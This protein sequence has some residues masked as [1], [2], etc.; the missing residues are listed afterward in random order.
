M[1]LDMISIGKAFSARVM[2]HALQAFDRA[3]MVV[4]AVC[5]GGAILVMVF[6]LYTL[7]LSMAAKHDAIEAAA[8]EPSVPQVVTTFPETTELQPLLERLQ[9]R[10]PDITFVLGGDKTLT[11][12]A[13]D[14]SKFRLWL[15]VLGYI[16]TVIPQYRWTMKEFCVGMQCGNAAPMKAVLTAEKITFTLPDAEKQ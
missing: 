5:W 16:D 3:M 10:F 11:V 1:K 2:T 7:N 12:T 9:K 15:T 13:V 4:V 8:S 6:A 14:G